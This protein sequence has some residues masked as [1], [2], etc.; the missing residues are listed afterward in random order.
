MSDVS[1]GKIIFS[2][3]VKSEI[4]AFPAW[5]RD[6]GKKKIISNFWWD[7]DFSYLVWECVK[8]AN[9]HRKIVMWTL[10][11]SWSRSWYF[12][13]EPY[14]NHYM[15]IKRAVLYIYIYI[16][17]YHSWQGF[18]VM[19]YFGNELLFNSLIWWKYICCI[20]ILFVINYFLAVAYVNTCQLLHSR[21]NEKNGLSVYIW[22]WNH[23]V[24]AFK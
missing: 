4:G 23:H 8:S 7:G 14:E 11:F 5:K 10:Y 1:W 18:V 3:Y 17:I 6:F 16:Y 13:M 9:L 12:D 24:Y 15:S 20:S 2:W 19:I 22:A 21:L